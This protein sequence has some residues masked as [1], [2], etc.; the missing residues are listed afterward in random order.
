MQGASLRGPDPA[1]VRSR[2]LHWY[3]RCRRELPWRRTRDPYAILVS[4]IMLQQTRV[5]TAL[6]Y[7]ERF[8]ERFPTV[9]RLAAAAEADVLQSWQGLG[10]YGRARN[11]WR[12]ARLIV[13]R[14]GGQVPGDWEALI[15]LPG[16]GEYTAGAVLSIAFDRPVAAVDGNAERVLARLFGVEEDL[17]RAP[18]RRAIREW[19]GR[20]VAGPRPGDV[21]QAI[22]ELGARV[23]TPRE[24]ACAACPVA[25]LCAARAAGCQ[26]ELP[27]RGRRAAVREQYFAV[28]WCLE[29]GRL[30][31]VRRPP[32]GLLAGL[33]A[34]PYTER[35]STESWSEAGR[36]LAAVLG[37]VLGRPV[38]V[39]DCVA[40]TRW[41]FTHRRWHL[42][43]YA[44]RPAGCEAKE[45]A[46]AATSPP[47]TL[48][49]TG[50]GA[51]IVAERGEGGGTGAAGEI[52]AEGPGAEEA[53]WEVRWVALDRVGE[54]PMSSLDRQ[55]IRS[56]AGA[57]PG[58][59]EQGPGGQGE[60]EKDREEPSE[61]GGR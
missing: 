39:D 54:L 44:V 4:E 60:P 38:R 58:A 5:E 20:L 59:G 45:G 49:V 34:L 42:R 16:I 17:S 52:R 24:P 27:R 61:R 2:L 10:Y 14:H 22:M 21:N 37:R 7:Y 11:L 1:E 40:R 53:G 29:A 18:G 41:E 48:P 13:E 47:G 9:E 25:V 32:Q 26:H 12:A 23:C 8:L 33:W 50:D 3:D 46:G 36:R 55:I 31:L 19:A 56:L 28:A 57:G 35:A 30:A 15:A 43:V 6:P 51:G